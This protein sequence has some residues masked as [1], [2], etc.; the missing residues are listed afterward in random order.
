MEQSQ[1][2]D[3]APPNFSKADPRGKLKQVGEWEFEVVD[4]EG[5][6]I[7]SGVSPHT[8]CPNCYSDLTLGKKYLPYITK[9]YLCSDWGSQLFSRNTFAARSI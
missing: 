9:Y 7:L 6:T 1:L 2:I 4:A 3:T 5:N 8:H